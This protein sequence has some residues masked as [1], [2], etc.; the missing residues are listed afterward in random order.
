MGVAAATGERAGRLALGD[1]V[2]RVADNVRTVDVVDAGR[3]GGGN[4]ERSDGEEVEE[5][6]ESHF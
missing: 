3:V 1:A 4:S 5:L 2:V 6:G